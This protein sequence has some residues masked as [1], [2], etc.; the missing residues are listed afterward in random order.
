MGIGIG[1]AGG[2][3]ATGAAGP[4]CIICEFVTSTN[5]SAVLANGLRYVP[6][7][8]GAAETLQF[9]FYAPDTGNY[10]IRIPY[11]MSAANAG[12]VELNVD[13]IA[14]GAGE[15]PAGA[16]STGADFVVTPGNDTLLDVVDEGDHASMTIAATA[17]D[18]VTVLLTR[19]NDAEDTHTGDMRIY[20][21]LAIKV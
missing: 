10:A 11:S 12:D 21:A 9:Q 5:A 14:I 8:N 17:G 7:N 6:L 1:L 4:A 16:L 18:M 15:D 2:V 20:C 19:T 13:S 3:G